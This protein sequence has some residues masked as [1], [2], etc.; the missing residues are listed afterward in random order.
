MR[1]KPVLAQAR[2]QP[3]A[4]DGVGVALEGSEPFDELGRRGS[5][6]SGGRGF[7]A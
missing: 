1:A 4:P 2:A 6:P 5:S 3:P 7:P